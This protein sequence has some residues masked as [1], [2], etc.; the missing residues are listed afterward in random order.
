[1]LR[2]SLLKKKIVFMAAL[3]SAS[4]AN[5]DF[6]Y[7]VPIKGLTFSEGAPAPEVLPAVGDGVSKAG[8]CVSGAASGCA[9]MTPTTSYSVTGD[10][11]TVT[12]EGNFVTSAAKA[13]VSKTSGKW[14]WEV[15]T[16]SPSTSGAIGLVLSTLPVNAANVCFGCS[17]NYFTGPTAPYLALYLGAYAGRALPLEI[18]KTGEYSAGAVAGFA[19]DLDTGTLAVTLD[20]GPRWKLSDIPAGGWAPV[21]STGSPFRHSHTFNFGQSNFKYPVPAGYNA[22]L[23]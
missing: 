20:G 8:A 10:G 18:I 3:A 21:V 11:L 17:A 22:G 19:L 12:F 23:W 1:M 7:R 6:E 4:L 14:Y 13:T 15:T 9:V 5:A 16:H 2:T